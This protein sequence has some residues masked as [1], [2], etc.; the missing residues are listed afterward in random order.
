MALLGGDVRYREC[1]YNLVQLAA[2]HVCGVE[3]SRVNRWSTLPNRSRRRRQQRFR[4][5]EDYR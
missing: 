5:R 2:G 1:S 3:A 4:D